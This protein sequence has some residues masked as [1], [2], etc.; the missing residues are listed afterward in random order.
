M[1]LRGRSRTLDLGYC[2]NVHAAESLNE[3]K[4][5]LAGPVAEVKARVSADAPFG[6]GL[7]L[8]GRA[9]RELA[10]PGESAAL[11]ERLERSGMYVFTIN[12]F[13]YGD[14]HGRAVKEGVYLP[15]WLDDRRLMYAND[16]A[17]VLAVLLPEGGRGTVSTVPGAFNARAKG[18]DAKTAIA[19]RMLSH[20][21]HLARVR[22]RTGR[23]V[24]LAVE[25]E[26]G[27][28][29]E[30]VDDLVRFFERYLFPRAGVELRQFF[31][32]CVDACHL[33]VG[34]EPP[35]G[36]LRLLAEAGIP[37][38]KV[39]V[40]AGIEAEFQDRRAL[41]AFDDGIYLHQ[42]SATESGRLTRW[43]DLDRALEHADE[44]PDAIWRVHCHVPIFGARLGAT[45]LRTTQP[46]LIELL[47]TVSTSAAATC[48]EIET[49][50][51]GV[52]PGAA[53]E[54]TLADAVARELAWARKQLEAA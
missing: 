20:A 44:C 13:P 46:N 16:L 26:P 10:R 40:S 34:F 53:V 30:T 38:E 47:D 11:R 45:R 25:P 23:T 19:C 1:K 7:R 21:T 29:L 32:I 50:T 27:C 41:A 12:G 8:S 51:W 35:E 28:L 3:V 33:A 52:L 42:V 4:A 24:T 48:F 37:I 36:S 2:T 15:D 54:G 39:Q 9:A 31:G 6:V 17:E 5:V 49:Y 43:L 18:E 14:F 22:E